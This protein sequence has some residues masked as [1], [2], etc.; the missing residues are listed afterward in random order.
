[1]SVSIE[2]LEKRI[3]K[4]EEENSLLHQELNFVRESPFLQTSI[5]NLIY[6]AIIDRAEVMTKEMGRRIN[7]KHGTMYEVKTQAKRLAMLLGIDPDMV[8]IMV[9]E[10]VQ[11]ILEHGEGTY[12]TVRLEICNDGENPYLI[13]SFKHDL[14]PGQRYTLSDINQNAL[15]GDVSSEYF[16]FESSRGRGEFIMKQLTDERRIINGIELNQNGEKVHY[17]KRTLINYRNPAGPRAKINFREIK[18]EIDRLDYEDVVCCF[19]VHHDTA[20]PDMVTVATTKAHSEKVKDVMASKSFK[21]TE[22][23]PYYRTVFATYVPDH[24]LDKDELLSLFS[25]VR[26]I[27]YQEIE[28]TPPE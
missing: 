11:N 20:R 1:M 24:P 19:H 6:E 5:K 28:E 26:H 2:D 9:T 14:P 17:F 18:E 10:A 25:K 7:E 3:N 22:Q 27:V 4:L 12:V 21:L 15:K 8:R 16:D 23:E 13:S